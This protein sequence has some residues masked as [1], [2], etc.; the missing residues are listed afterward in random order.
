MGWF[1]KSRS[2]KIFSGLESS[3]H[4][5]KKR[6]FFLRSSSPW[7]FSTQVTDFCPA[8]A[9]KKRKLNPEEEK[10]L[11][12]LSQLV[13]EQGPFDIGSL[14]E[15]QALVNAGLSYALVKGL[16]LYLCNCLL[17]FV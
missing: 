11:K 12:G 7:G 10:T 4:S 16:S 15:E 17:T 5:W 2:L 6:F 3:I 8:S 14:L 9:N 13:A 1:Y